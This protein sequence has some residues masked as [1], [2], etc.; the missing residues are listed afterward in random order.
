MNING[1]IPLPN[2]T[3]FEAQEVLYTCIGKGGLYRIVGR[4]RGAGT[5]RDTGVI[6]VY[7]DV[8]S[9]EHMP[10]FRTLEDFNK[11]MQ[12]VDMTDDSAED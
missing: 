12:E 2:E 6:I 9:L 4:A 10:F 3:V 5:S 7:E 11:R 8:N 1:R